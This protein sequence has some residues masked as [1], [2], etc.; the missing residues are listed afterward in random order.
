MLG[1]IL[2]VFIGQKYYRLA[3]GYN[4]TNPW[5]YP[6]LGIITYYVGSIL[7]GGIL[8]GLAIEFLSSSSIDDFS[9]TA[10]GL[11]GLPFGLISVYA[12]YFILKKKWQKSFV[13]VRDEI[14]DIGKSSKELDDV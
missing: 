3:K 5:V 1:I 11:M 7:F 9:D 2:L 4:I 8:I 12:L 6:I 10:F 14:Q 13:E